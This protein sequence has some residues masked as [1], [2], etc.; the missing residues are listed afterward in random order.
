MLILE[1]LSKEFRIKI[2]IVIFLFLA[3]QVLGCNTTSSVAS[4][5][6][7]IDNI[8]SIGNI[9]SLNPA[10][11][12]AK[13]DT[14]SDSK[15]IE[16]SEKT[17]F[18]KVAKKVIRISNAEQLFEEVCK[19]ENSL[20]IECP[21]DLENRILFLSNGITIIGEEAAVLYNGVVIG[22]GVENVR[23]K[24]L[25]FWG[26]PL[27]FSASCKSIDVSYCTF[28]GDENGTQSSLTILKGLGVEI[29]YCEFIG[30]DD[31]QN[32]LV[33][34]GER[35]IIA[36]ECQVQLHNCTFEGN[37]SFQSKAAMVHLYNCSFSYL[38]ESEE[39]FRFM[40]APGTAS[41]Y[42]IENCLFN[43]GEKPILC[44]FDV[45]ATSYAGTFSWIYQNKC[46]PEITDDKCIYDNSDAL[47][48]FKHHL[49]SK[50]MWQIPYQYTLEMES[51]VG[52]SAAF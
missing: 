35:N 16:K 8:E 51:R 38:E 4:A 2:S 34:L 1:R 20:I 41:Q 28:S 18:H 50:K 14:K 10:D 3:L 12:I 32:P 42:I 22:E 27:T 48:S 25:T 19:A 13:A 44:Y 45:S 47:K 39:N 43:S 17:D 5:L 6:P 26:C 29:S 24:A 40:L 15:K 36:S 9:E 30:E 46:R 31:S 7:S 23:L 49:S 33:M 52:S 11:E 37:A 21:I